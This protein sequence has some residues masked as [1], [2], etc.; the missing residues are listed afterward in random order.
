MR[1]AQAVHLMTRAVGYLNS[2]WMGECVRVRVRVCKG[3]G[4][5]VKKERTRKK[6][7]NRQSR[8]GK[9]KVA[10]GK[11]LGGSEQAVSGGRVEVMRESRW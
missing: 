5:G 6:D 10:G 1:I 11:V 2:E 9:L 3:N 7:D 4:N 8:A